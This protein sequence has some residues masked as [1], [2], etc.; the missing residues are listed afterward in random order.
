MGIAMF[1]YTNSQNRNRLTDVKSK[2]PVTKEETWG[3]DESGGWDGHKHAAAHKTDN[4][5]GPTV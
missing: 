5:Q 2:L 4:Q 3:K 1:R